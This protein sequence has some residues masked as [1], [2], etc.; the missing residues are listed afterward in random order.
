MTRR[1]AATIKRDELV[2]MERERKARCANVRVTQPGVIRGFDAMHMIC[3]DGRFYWLV[4][5]DAAV[6]YRTSIETVDAYDEDSVIAALTADFEEH[7][8]PLVARLDRASCQR[9]RAVLERLERYEVLVLHGP[10]H[11]PQYYGQ[12]ERQNLEHRAWLSSVDSLTR[13][14]LPEVAARMKTALNALWARPTLNW[15]TAEQVWRARPTINVDRTQL[16]RH[17]ERVATGLENTGLDPI[18]A[19]R[20]AIESALIERGLL[21]INFGGHR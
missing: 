5:A 8:P 14:G 6:P 9:T 4:A 19:Q 12:L 15:C 2:T 7:G 16:R 10:P 1:Q 3:R 11:H 13:A 18:V 17:V 21:T 20:R